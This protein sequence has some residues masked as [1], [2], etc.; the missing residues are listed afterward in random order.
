VARAVSV[1]QNQPGI[2]YQ[3]TPN[4]TVLEGDLKA[5]LE[6]VPQMQDAV[7]G[8]GAQRVLTTI[9][10]DERRDKPTSMEHKL[11]SVQEKLNQR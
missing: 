1:L 2:K 9:I 5:I 8:A 11:K 10:I 4:G 3:I 6:I 7:F